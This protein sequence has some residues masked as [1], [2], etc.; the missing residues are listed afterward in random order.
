MGYT[1]MTS[2]GFPTTAEELRE[3]LLIAQQQTRE[4]A[5]TID[6]QR[7]QLETNRRR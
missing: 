2:D 6:S 1:G 5:A 7:R 4:L 3:L